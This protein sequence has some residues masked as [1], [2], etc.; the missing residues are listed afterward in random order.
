MKDIVKI[1]YQILQVKKDIENRESYIDTLQS[2]G[3]VC[4]DVTVHSRCQ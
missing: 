2:S 1:T 4:F 3:G